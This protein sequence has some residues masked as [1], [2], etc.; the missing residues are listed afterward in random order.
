MGKV[1]SELVTDYPCAN[2]DCD[3]LFD[4]RRAELGLLAL[5]MQCGREL[6]S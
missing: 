2:P 6:C 4:A 5:C 3:V 1:K